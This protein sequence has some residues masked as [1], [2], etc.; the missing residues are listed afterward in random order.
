M[1]KIKYLLAMSLMLTACSNGGRQIKASYDTDVFYDYMLEGHTINDLNYVT[2]TDE[3]SMRLL[4]NVVDGLIEQD[5][6]GNLTPALALTTGTPSENYTVWDFE[7]RPNIPWADANGEK[8]QYTLTAEDFVSGIRYSLDNG[9][10]DVIMEI[11]GLLAN[12]DSYC[13]GEANFKDVGVKAIDDTHIRFTLTRPCAYFN[14][15]LVHGA[16]YPI[17]TLFYK[18]VKEDFAT[19]P[20]NML[21]NGC[22]YLESVTD[23]KISFVK[24][25]NYWQADQVTFEKAE[26][27]SV[28]DENEAFELFEKGKLS[29]SFMAS[30]FASENKNKYDKHMY[31]ES[32]DPSSYFVGY[33]F[34]SDNP[35][36]SLAIQ[37]D[38]FRKALK[39]GFSMTSGYAAA[40]KEEVNNIE[41]KKEQALSKNQAS[42][43]F[44]S[45][46]T[47][48]GF[49]ATSK[50]QDYVTLGSLANVSHELIYDSEKALQEMS[51]AKTELIDTVSFPVNIRVPICVDDPNNLVMAE[52]IMN[53]Y[54]TLFDTNTNF[55]TFELMPY[56]TQEN[57]ELSNEVKN[58]II[59]F[60]STLANNRYDMILLNK[61][62]TNGD[63]ST[64]LQEFTLEG[65]LNKTYIHMTDTLYTDLFNSANE[66]V[67]EDSR[68]SVLAE[69]EAYLIEKGYIIPFSHGQATYK[70]SSINDFSV[71]RGFY[72]LA[73]YKLKGIIAL[74]SCVTLDE[75]K[76]FQTTFE[77][78]KNS[79]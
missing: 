33:N 13:Q 51:L 1:K 47:P 59:N 22:Y 27:K 18:Q 71:P 24:N 7:I 50:Y 69:C 44:Q 37:N 74:E 73:H 9:Q 46:I 10:S 11:R 38:H 68:L 54:K 30:E 78:N 79:Q 6:Y 21:Y 63:P 53:N 26:I 75:R 29:Y 31:I 36:F 41:E 19:T 17:P 61:K 56:I 28:K 35:N 12:A 14:S 77:T 72:G 49:V 39:Y 43:D 65:N 16:F 20:E 52:N 40:K 23:E 3:N 58:Q 66:V 45:T 34:S 2:T 62:A 25:E 42:L 57:V 48:T 8:T 4:G 55:I 5:R 76:E 64:Y 60:A 67:D 70:V 15:Y 32:K